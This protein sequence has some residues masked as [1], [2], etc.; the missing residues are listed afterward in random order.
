MI[1]DSLKNSELYYGVNKNFKEAFEFIKKA[2]EENLPVGRYEL[3]GN[4]LFAMIQEY[5]TKSPEEAKAEAHRKYIDIQYIISGI[6]KMEVYNIS[7]AETDIAYSE[8]KDCEFFKNY[9]IPSVCI[10][11]NEE[12]AILF[13]EDIHRPGMAYDNPAAVKKIVVKVAVN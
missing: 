5:N 12:Y 1:F 10:L 2:T 8:E 9:E 3:K 4:D 6:E 11:Q 7:K 13:P